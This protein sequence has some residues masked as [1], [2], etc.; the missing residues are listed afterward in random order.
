MVLARWEIKITT[1]AARLEAKELVRTKN[2]TNVR[3]RIQ[4]SPFVGETTCVSQ[5]D[6]MC[7]YPSRQ[8]A[9][10]RLI[11]NCHCFVQDKRVRGINSVLGGMRNKHGSHEA[12]SQL[13]LL[14]QSDVW[15]PNI[16][17]SASGRIISAGGHSRFGVCHRN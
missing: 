1:S 6:R 4:S 2:Q 12:L 7:V 8:S 5:L 15:P 9:L 17:G 3:A 13:L 14:K 16:A 11:V 10:S